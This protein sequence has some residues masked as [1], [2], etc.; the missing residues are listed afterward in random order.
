MKQFSSV[1][2]KYSK[3]TIK[4]SKT[5]TFDMI[6]ELLHDLELFLFKNDFRRSLFLWV[7]SC[8][9]TKRFVILYYNE[10]KP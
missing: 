7:L 8:Q 2:F 10:K 5:P 3:K 6:V 4:F 9:K 1:K